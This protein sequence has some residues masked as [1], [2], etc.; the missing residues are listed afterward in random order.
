MIGVA[1]DTG[2]V[3]SLI[4]SL[5]ELAVKDDHR[6]LLLGKRDLWPALREAIPGIVCLPSE[7]FP[8]L[9]PLFPKLKNASSWVWWGS[10]LG[11]PATVLQEAHRD[12]RVTTLQSLYQF[13]LDVDSDPTA[14]TVLRQAC[15]T[16]LFGVAESDPRAWFVETPVIAVESPNAVL[17]RTLAMAALE[18]GT[19]LV[20]WHA[21]GFVP[22]DRVVLRR[23]HSIIYPDAAWVPDVLVTRGAD[24][25]LPNQ[26]QQ[27]AS[28]LGVGEATLYRRS[29][30]RVARVSVGGSSARF[31]E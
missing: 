3:E 4:V 15:Q 21:P 30:G 29:E 20:V 9:N 22:S 7:Q 10:G 8:M 6:L 17:S 18:S 5:I 2:S 31:R 13:A 28:E 11:I 27:L 12:G 24:A 26:I 19:Y 25:T 14:I 16:G 1:G 23:A